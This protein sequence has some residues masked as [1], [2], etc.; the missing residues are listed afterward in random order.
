MRFTAAMVKLGLLQRLWISK[1]N[2][3]ASEGAKQ[4]E[5]GGRC[6][7]LELTRML[8][9]L[10]VVKY[11]NNMSK[12][13]IVRTARDNIDMLWN[14][15]NFLRVLNEERVKIRVLHCSGTIKRQEI[16]AKRY[17][18]RW[19][20]KM[21]INPT[22][23]GKVR[24]SLIKN[25]ALARTQL[26]TLDQW[27]KERHKGHARTVIKNKA[28]RSHDEGTTATNGFTKQLVRDFSNYPSL[29]AI[30]QCSIGSIYCSS[31]PISQSSAL[32][33]K[34]LALQM[35]FREQLAS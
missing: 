20:H 18:S 25:H 17:L 22:V 27:N 13:F 31:W 34:S 12:L 11:V 7:W 24:D 35:L 19:M 8:L 28:Q 9:R 15:L 32:T 1:V 14:S 26:E 16:T 29:L 23:I 10:S 5:E 4:K 33:S 21:L 2:K 6:E 30:N 3:Q